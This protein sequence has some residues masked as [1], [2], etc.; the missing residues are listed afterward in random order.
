M[1][2]QKLIEPAFPPAPSNNEP[3]GGPAVLKVELST[4]HLGSACPLLTP[5]R[6][7]HFADL[8]DSESLLEEKSIG[9][10]SGTT[11][12]PILRD[13]SEDHPRGGITSA[14][15]GP[16][17]RAELVQFSSDAPLT[18]KYPCAGWATIMGGSG[19]IGKRTSQDSVLPRTQL[20]SMPKMTTSSVIDTST[21]QDMAAGTMTS[22]SAVDTQRQAECCQDGE[23]SRNRG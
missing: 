10:Q 15:S 2:G 8:I 11:P 12:W 20:P 5:A 22:V 6:G 14:T 1:T 18:S 17:T 21:R 4:S 3:T 16:E 19:R 13:S 7:A 23:R 9:D